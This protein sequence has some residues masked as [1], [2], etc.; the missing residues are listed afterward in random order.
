MFYLLKSNHNIHSYIE[1]PGEFLDNDIYVDKQEKLMWIM[2]HCWQC[3]VLFQILCKMYNLDENLNKS[4]TYSFISSS[5]PYN[6]FQVAIESVLAIIE[7][8]NI[9]ITGWNVKLEGV[10]LEYIFHDINIELVQKNN[11]YYIVY[12]AHGRYAIYKRYF[13]S[14]C[15]TDFIPS[16]PEY[17]IGTDW[18]S[19]YFLWSSNYRFSQKIILNETQIES[20]LND[21][22]FNPDL[23]CVK[24]TSAKYFIALKQLRQCCKQLVLLIALKD[25][26]LTDYAYLYEVNELIIYINSNDSELSP[27]AFKLFDHTW[28]LIDKNLVNIEHKS[29]VDF[30][31]YGLYEYNNQIHLNSTISTQ[32]SHSTCSVFNSLRKSANLPTP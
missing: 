21:T 22:T 17:T 19:E 5:L 12:G 13:I 14:Q 24:F 28:C 3:D 25:F 1:S 9:V 18:N 32:S 26:P 11:N 31:N 27:I 20:F 10:V 4:Y 2:R 8:P 7:N 16:K 15:D 29:I 6:M 30:N 23:L